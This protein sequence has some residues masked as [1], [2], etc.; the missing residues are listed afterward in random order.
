M[1]IND[2]ISGQTLAKQKARK[3]IRSRN[4]ILTRVSLFSHSLEKSEFDTLTRKYHDF[5]D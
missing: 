1:G 2:I 5:V 3:I 4:L